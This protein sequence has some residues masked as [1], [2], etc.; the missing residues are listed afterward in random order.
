MAGHHFTLHC[1]NGHL[2][3]AQYLIREEHC[4]PSCENNIWLHHH[5]CGDHLL[6]YGSTDWSSILACTGEIFTRQQLAQ[7]MTHSGCG[8][9]RSKAR[10]AFDISNTVY[11][12]IRTS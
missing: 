4:N 11:R 1:D 3:I 2:N 7:A 12:Y 10:V 5:F 6:E 9:E 8:V